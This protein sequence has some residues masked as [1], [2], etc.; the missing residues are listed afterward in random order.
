MT[1]SRPYQTNTI[2]FR[3]EILMTNDQ[4]TVAYG[5]REEWLTR[6][7]FTRAAFSA[8]WVATALTAG[9]QSLA[10][11]AALLILYPAWDAAANLIDA[12]RN[13]G[14]ANNRSQAINVAVSAVTTAAMIVALTMS[15][16]WVLG[17]FG[18]WAIFS[19]LL[20]LR[21]AVR[22]WKTNGGQWAMILSGGQSAVA[23]AFFIAQAQ[24]PEPPSIANVAG[25]AGLGAFYFLV[26]AAWR[27]VTQMRRKRA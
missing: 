24:L 27:S 8:I 3:K 15:M 13:G 9:R 11:A 18:L 20:Q 16:N 4:T 26:S 23:G 12:A 10:V 5:D 17:V 1:V 14:L 6:Y 22:R 7:Y 2:T 21:T 25:Y 19:G